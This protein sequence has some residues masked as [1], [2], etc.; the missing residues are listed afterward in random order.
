MTRRA[1]SL[2]N[3]FHAALRLWESYCHRTRGEAPAFP[4]PAAN[5]IGRYFAGKN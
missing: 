1:E 2:S 4:T 5:R 3:R